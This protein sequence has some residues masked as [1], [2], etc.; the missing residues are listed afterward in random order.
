MRELWRTGWLHNRAR[1]VVGSFLTKDLMLPWQE[2]AAWFMDTLVD[3]DLADNAMG[4]Q[5]MAGCGV[6]A[7]PYFRIFNPIL[8]S[9]KFDPDGAYIRRWVPE[10]AGLPD[11]LIH[12]PF[13][14]GKAD[15]RQAGVRLGETYPHPIVDHYRARAIAL[16]AYRSVRNAG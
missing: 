1:L 5:W 11:K 14:A 16:E 10:L 15:L 9:R 4:W 8:Q 13:E 6:D 7:S 2:G 12:A 3:A